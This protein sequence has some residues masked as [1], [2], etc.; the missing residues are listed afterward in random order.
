[1]YDRVRKL[2]RADRKSGW[3]H[4][5]KSAALT[6]F[7]CCFFLL[8]TH[9]LYVLQLHSFNNNNNNSH[10]SQISVHSSALPSG[11]DFRVLV[12]GHG[13]F[14]CMLKRTKISSVHV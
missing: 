12:A 10:N 14:D 6:S 3:R 2:N 9:F 8:S 7:F 4:E 13:R 1:M 5:E 11:Y